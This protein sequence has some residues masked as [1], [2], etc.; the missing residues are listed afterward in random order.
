LKPAHDGPVELEAQT[1]SKV[2]EHCNGI[3]FPSAMNW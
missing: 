1:T 3:K 2:T